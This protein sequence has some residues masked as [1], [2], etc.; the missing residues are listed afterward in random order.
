MQT[1]ASNQKE[2]E[3]H[4]RRNRF[5]S[6]GEFF[7]AVPRTKRSYKTR[8]HFIVFDSK[9]ASRITAAGAGPKAFHVHAIRID[10]DLVC[11][12]SARF[13]VPT[14]NFGDHKNTRRRV[15]VQ[16][17]VSFQQVKIAHAVPVFAD[18]N[19]RTVIFEKQRT[20]RTQGSDYS[21]PTKPRVALINKVRLRAF[22]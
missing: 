14:L 4:T 12:D 11:S 21:C 10:N 22:D 8:D 9:F 20:L 18:P 5:N 2:P 16:S 17:F 15:K 19:L 6:L 7:N 13:K 1:P 3:R